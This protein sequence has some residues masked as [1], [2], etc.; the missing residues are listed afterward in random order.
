[1]KP[2]ITMVTKRVPFSNP[3]GAVCWNCRAAGMGPLSRST[4]AWQGDHSHLRSSLQ[5]RTPL[6]MGFPVLSILLLLF[7]LVF[8]F[9]WAKRWSRKPRGTLSISL[10]PHPLYAK[11]FRWGLAPR[12]RALW[13]FHF[14]IDPC[15]ALEI[16][17][18][19]DRWKEGKELVTWKSFRNVPSV[20][21][22]SLTV[23]CIWGT[24]VQKT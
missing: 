24:Q 16:R 6:E 15:L 19:D 8:L 18:D 14:T 11:A 7:Y 17:E 22:E 3:E 12:E 9:Y 4:L 20:S 5:N 21:T 13:C 2:Y 23:T 1:M 10:R